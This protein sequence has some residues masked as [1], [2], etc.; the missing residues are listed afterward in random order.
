LHAFLLCMQF[1]LARAT[2]LAIFASPKLGLSLP[3]LGI[4][5]K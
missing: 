1:Y 5:S 2:F 3:K 4:S